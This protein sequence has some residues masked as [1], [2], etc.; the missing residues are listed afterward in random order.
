MVSLTYGDT[1]VAA[2]ESKIAATPS[3]APR[4][5]W[6]ARFFAALIAARMRQAEREIR[7]H[8][9]GVLPLLPLEDE[10]SARGGW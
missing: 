10:N 9:P 5:T 8:A 4:Q 7:L 2:P 1:R 6:F 3:V